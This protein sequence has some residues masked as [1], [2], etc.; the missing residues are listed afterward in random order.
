MRTEQTKKEMQAKESV[1]MT[2]E[3]LTVIMQ[4]ID[5]GIRYF[6]HFHPKD[7]DY[8]FDT[9]HSKTEFRLKKDQIHE[10]RYKFTRQF[11]D[12]VLDNVEDVVF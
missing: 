9:G 6:D 8:L 10:V 11:M 2:V 12:A 1:E 5:Q 4:L 3:E 7:V